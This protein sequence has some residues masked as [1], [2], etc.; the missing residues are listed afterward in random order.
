LIAATT[1]DLEA[2]AREGSLLEG[3]YRRLAEASIT[4]PPLRER[5]EDIPLLVNQFLERHARRLGKAVTGVEPAAMEALV[6]HPWPGNVREL[7]NAVERGLILATGD[8]LALEDLPTRITAAPGGA[9]P[10][11]SS[12]SYEEA[13]RHALSR[14]D[15][16]YL[17]RLLDTHQNN[18]EGAAR[19][20]G[21]DPAEFRRRA[22]A[23]GIGIKDE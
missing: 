9:G 11:E 17:N 6:A 15:R 13:R 21:L 3:L 20:A 2:R 19:E 5:R 4:A 8:S 12:L 18:V 16:D 14:F 10:P 23:A 22:E 7:A 1:L